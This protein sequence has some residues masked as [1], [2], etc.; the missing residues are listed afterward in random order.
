VAIRD[1]EGNRRGIAV[2]GGTGKRRPEKLGG[3]GPGRVA[4][5]KKEGCDERGFR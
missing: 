3:N 2:G 5:Q 1:H 4:E